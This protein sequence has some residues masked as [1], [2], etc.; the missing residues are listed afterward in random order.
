MTIF[1][2]ASMFNEQYQ[3][4]SKVFDKCDLFIE[5]SMSE[6]NIALKEAALKALKDGCSEEEYNLLTEAAEKSFIERS[7][8]TIAHFVE[9]LRKFIDDCKQKIIDTYTSVKTSTF[10]TKVQELFTKDPSLKST[11]VEYTETKDAVKECD[12]VLTKL[13]MKAT[14]ISATG[15]SD[16][17]KDEIETTKET[18]FKKISTKMAKASMTMMEAMTEIMNNSSETKIQQNFGGIAQNDPMVKLA[19]VVE[20]SPDAQTAETVVAASSAMCRISKEKFSLKVIRQSSIMQGIKDAIGNLKKSDKKE[21]TK[22]ESVYDL[23]VFNLNV[24]TERMNEM[25]PD[26]VHVEESMILGMHEGLDLDM[27]FDEVCKSID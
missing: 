8:E 2:Q 20:S 22:T 4:T 3:A 5:A 9:V 13:K 25:I 26:E 18:L 7:K 19:S 27:Y 6:Y 17:D 23:P 21:T 24:Y 10:V 11:K 14:K 12:N 1:E 16:S 15:A